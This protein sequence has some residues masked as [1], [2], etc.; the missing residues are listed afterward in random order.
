MV[1]FHFEGAHPSDILMRGRRVLLDPR[2]PECSLACPQKLGNMEAP[3]PPKCPQDFGG[4][5]LSPSGVKAPL[6]TPFL[7]RGGACYCRSLPS[8]NYR[9]STIKGLGQPESSGLGVLGSEGGGL[10][11]GLSNRRDTMGESAGAEI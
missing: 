9:T 5:H 3:H 7:P 11:Q 8:L 1:S 2:G 4:E 6:L 10:A